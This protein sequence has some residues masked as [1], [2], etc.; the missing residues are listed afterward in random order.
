MDALPKTAFE[1]RA[2]A[3]LRRTAFTLLELLVVVAIIGILAAL[4]L[5]ALSAAHQKARC[6]QCN[7]NLQQI[8]IAF[9]M[10]AQE[11]ADHLPQRYYGI[12]SNG[13]SI[14]YDEVLIPYTGS[15]NAKT[16]IAQLFLCPSQRQTD[17]PKQPGYGMN[18]YYDNIA[19]GLVGQQ[20]ATILVAETLGPEGT[21]SHRAD[22]DSGT[23]GELDP[24]RHSH[25]ANYLFLDGHVNLS[26]WTNTVSPD[27]WGIDQGLHDAISNN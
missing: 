14:G 13:M 10:Y 16:N 19:L 1:T 20:S 7:N 18:W 25:R 11:H 26:S 17:Y 8:G 22:R 4:L 12:N 21:G 6:A 15:S 24:E 5:P 3:S 9:T 27:L 2:G 23:P